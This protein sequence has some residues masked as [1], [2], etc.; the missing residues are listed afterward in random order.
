MA[1]MRNLLWFLPVAAFLLNPSFACSDDDEATF[2]FG[3]TEMRAA[4][5]GDWSFA[6]TP[7]LAAP[8][9]R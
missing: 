8:P 3:A 1:G 5:Q 9:R 7:T 6:I 4:V 2:Q